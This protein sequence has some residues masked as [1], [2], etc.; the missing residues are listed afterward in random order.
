MRATIG[1]HPPGATTSRSLKT[2][3]TGLVQVSSTLHASWLAGYMGLSGRV[4]SSW[5]KARLPIV[6]DGSG[7]GARYPVTTAGSGSVAI[8]IGSNAQGSHTGASRATLWKSANGPVASTA[9]GRGSFGSLSGNPVFEIT[10]RSTSPGFSAARRM[11][12][13]PPQSC[14][15]MSTS[16]S[17]S[18]STSSARIHSTWRATV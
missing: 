9:S 11:P 8:T 7:Y 5:V 3:S 13:T 15:T 18:S 1:F 10:M 17:A 14:S 16:A 6:S 2:V 12:T 4:G